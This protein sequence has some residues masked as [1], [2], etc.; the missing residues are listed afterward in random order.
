MRK[1]TRYLVL[2]A[3][4]LPFFGFFLIGLALFV[5]AG[6]LG[7]VAF[8]TIFTVLLGLPFFYFL[9]RY[10][11]EA[12]RE[13]EVQNLVALLKSYGRVSLHALAERMGKGEAEMELAV[14]EALADG[15]LRG[16]IDPD[17]RIFY[18]GTSAPEYEPA[19]TET[20][21]VEVPLRRPA[22]PERPPDEIRYCRECG[23]QVEW[24]VEEGRWHCPSCG[25]YQL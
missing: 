11:R 4:L 12:G 21:V 14:V 24:V 8:L 9:S 7:L 2:S 15:S 23:R 13:K 20:R 17:T 1:K 16:F 5:A 25:N 3:I 22:L 19:V 18:Y 6:D 10:R